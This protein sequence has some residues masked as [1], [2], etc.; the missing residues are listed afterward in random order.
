MI[1]VVKIIMVGK[2]TNFSNAMK[3]LDLNMAQKD[4]FGLIWIVSQNNSTHPTTCL[5]PVKELNR[6]MASDASVAY[7]DLAE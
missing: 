7:I 5:K 2:T 6:K 1:G 4:Q 3:M